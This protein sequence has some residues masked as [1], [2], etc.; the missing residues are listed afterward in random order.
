MLVT[1]GRDLIRLMV[2]DG[3]WIIVHFS[4]FFLIWHIHIP[5]GWFGTFL[6]IPYIGSNHPNWLSYFSELKPPAI[7]SIDYLYIK[8]IE[9][10]SIGNDTTNSRSHIFS[11]GSTTNE[12][13]HVPG[14][15]CSGAAGRPGRLDDARTMTSKQVIGGATLGHTTDLE[16][17]G[18]NPV[19]VIYIR[20]SYTIIRWVSSSLFIYR[21]VWLLSCSFSYPIII[22]LPA[23]WMI[24]W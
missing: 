15:F 21:R 24:P 1:L 3:Q 5:G 11:E 14:L 19:K 12:T 16:N 23:S 7:L 18:R 9:T 4:F 13:S 6:Y 20:W 22:H 8:H 10:I 2:S 17:P